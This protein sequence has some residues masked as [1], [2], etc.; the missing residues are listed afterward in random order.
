MSFLKKLVKTITKI[1]PSAKLLKK[2]PLAKKIAKVSPGVGMASKL[3]KKKK[4]AVA[5]TTTKAPFTK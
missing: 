2:H 3:L 5:S 1:S 4:P